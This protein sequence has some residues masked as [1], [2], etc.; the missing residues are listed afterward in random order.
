MVLNDRKTPDLGDV[1]VTDSRSLQVFC[2]RVKETLQTW[3]GR[4]GTD[5]QRGVRWGDLTRIGAAVKLP[6]GQFVGADD[7]A[8]VDRNAPPQAVFSSVTPGFSHLIVEWVPPIYTQGG[9]HAYTEVWAAQYSGT[10][11]LPTFSAAALVSKEVAP[12][13]AFPAGMGVQV[14]FWLINRSKADVAQTVPT[15]GVNGVYATSGE[16][17]DNSIDDTKMV[18]LSVVKLLAGNLAVGSYIRSTSYMAGLFGWAIDADGNVE[19]NN[20]T[21]RG[22]LSGATGSFSGLLTG[23]IMAST[24]FDG[25][26]ALDGSISNVGTQGWAL[27]KN[28]GLVVDATHVRGQRFTS[29][30]TE[31]PSY[32][33]AATNSFTADH[34]FSQATFGGYIVQAG[35]TG[36]VKVYIDTDGPV[37]CECAMQIVA[38]RTSDLAEIEGP[39]TRDTRI[40]QG[41]I[42]SAVPGENMH[43]IPI[44]LTWLFSGDYTRVRTRAYGTSGIP[45]TPV[46]VDNSLNAAQWTLFLR[47]TVSTTE[48]ASPYGPETVI[49]HAR[50]D[51][52]G[53]AMELKGAETSASPSLAGLPA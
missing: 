25:A 7:P 40:L 39:I 13:F 15:G 42:E 33:G 50:V 46:V 10:G 44:S 29:G 8:A 37:V 17:P 35:C 27:G 34:S 31:Q 6:S 5:L 23:S 45:L 1:N 28:G 41:G 14:H 16:I 21:F 19:F 51:L 12:I 48:A 32:S 49:T 36:S 43:A 52:G 26:F 22:Q 47:L 4:R 18:S 20:G 3:E 24:N 2:D 9:G 30:R 53:W 11:P 38:V